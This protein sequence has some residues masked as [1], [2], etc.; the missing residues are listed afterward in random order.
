MKLMP[1]DHFIFSFC[2]LVCLFNGFQLFLA[3]VA[4]VSRGVG[5]REIR[6]AV[7]VRP[8]VRKARKFRGI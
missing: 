6:G 5:R 8:F 2:F 3:C 4:G 1:P 7:L